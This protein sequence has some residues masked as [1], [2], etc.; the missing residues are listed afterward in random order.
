[1]HTNR[2]HPVMGPLKIGLCCQNLLQWRDGVSLL[3]IL[4]WP[5]QNPRPCKMSLW[6]CRVEFQRPLTM[7]FRLLHPSVLRVKAEM[8]VCRDI[9]QR[10]VRQRTFGLALNGSRQMLDGV[11]QDFRPICVTLAETRHEFV[12]SFR[13]AAVSVARLLRGELKTAAQRF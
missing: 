7:V 12:I 9:G 6:Q 13:V 1:M 2:C 11:L 5:P 3:E 10:S 8:H 4:G